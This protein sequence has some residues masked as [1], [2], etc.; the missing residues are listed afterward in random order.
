[1]QAAGVILREF[2]LCVPA[3]LEGGFSQPFDSL[4]VLD[5]HALAVEVGFTEGLLRSGVAFLRRPSIPTDRFRKITV[6]AE[7][8]FVAPAEFMNGR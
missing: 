7:A 6:R 5:G 2:E 3:S 1:M 4:K 8:A